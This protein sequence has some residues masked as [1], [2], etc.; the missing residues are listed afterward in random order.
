M[1]SS[2]TRGGCLCGGNRV[3]LGRVPVLCPGLGMSIAL[4]AQPALTTA[5]AAWFKPGL[6]PAFSDE[7]PGLIFAKKEEHGLGW[8]AALAGVK[9]GRWHG[10]P[11]PLL[12]EPGQKLLP[13]KVCVAAPWAGTGAR[14]GPVLGV[15]CP[16]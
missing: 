7:V 6:S 15:A 16:P 12:S 9:L 3:H 4:S 5:F 14:H 10:L 13:V 11:V 8:Q 2:P 1:P